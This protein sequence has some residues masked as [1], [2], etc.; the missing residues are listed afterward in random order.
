MKLGIGITPRDDIPTAGDIMARTARATEDAGLDSVWFF[1]SLAR[2]YMSLDPLIGAS[3]AAAVTERIEVGI[4][5]LM[6]PIRHPVELANSV[7]TA[8]MACEGRLLLGVGSGSTKGDFD[9]V[10]KPFDQRQRMLNDGIATMRKLWRGEEVDG[11]SLSPIASVAGGP[12]VLIGSWAGS[13]W[14][15]RAAQEFDGWVASSHRVGFATLADGIGRFRAAGGKR[16]VVTNIWLDLDAPT[17]PIPDDTFNLMCDPVEARRRLQ[18][19]A[20]LGFDDAVVVH[21]GSGEPDYGAIRAL[22]G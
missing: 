5:I 3:V 9:A 12:R 16:A 10:G 21:H 17:G 19:L 18:M 20:D 14:I 22:V 1:D 7:L 13:K 11:V 4:S 2:G 6:V 15:P 8:H